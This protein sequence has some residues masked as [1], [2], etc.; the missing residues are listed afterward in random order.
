MARRS[1]DVREDFF[2]RGA[3][4][5]VLEPSAAGAGSGN[6]KGKRARMRLFPGREG[7][8]YVTVQVDSSGVEMR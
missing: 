3:E 4:Y 6:L 8:A 5:V 7:V 2:V 1:R